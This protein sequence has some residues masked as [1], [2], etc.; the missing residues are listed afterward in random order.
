VPSE[1]RPGRHGHHLCD[2]CFADIV[3]VDG[4]II[5]LLEGSAPVSF[6]NQ[7]LKVIIAA[8]S[9]L[10]VEAR[11]D[12]LPRSMPSARQT[13][14]LRFAFV[15]IGDGG[16]HGCEGDFGKDVFS[17]EVCCEVEWG[18]TSATRKTDRQGQRRRKCEP[19]IVEG[20]DHP[21]TVTR[22]S[23]VGARRKMPNPRLALVSLAERPSAT[24]TR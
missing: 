16:N 23:A 15:A 14:I 7:Q 21:T 17:K 4:E 6:S 8:A 9:S 12:F 11:D 18:G 22:A 3:A 10:P 13:V 20:Q 2:T 19:L 24:P 1:R 5:G